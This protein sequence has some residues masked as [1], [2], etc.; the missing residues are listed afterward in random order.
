[1]SMGWRSWIDTVNIFSLI[2]FYSFSFYNK[3]S[4]SFFLHFDFSFGFF[5]GFFLSDFSLDSFSRWLIS[6]NN[7]F[8]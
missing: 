1:M 3:F 7:G 2:D 4:L 8:S 6:T 5:D